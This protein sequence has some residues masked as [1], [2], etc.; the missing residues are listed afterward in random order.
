MAMIPPAPGTF[1][2]TTG[3][4]VRSPSLAMISRVMRSYEP[5]GAPGMVT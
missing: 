4:P 2:I 1:M 5:P 3:T